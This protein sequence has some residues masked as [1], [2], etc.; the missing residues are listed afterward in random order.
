MI[1]D[2]L[3]ELVTSSQRILLLQG[4]IGPFFKYFADWLVNV[5]GKYVYKLNFNAGDKFYFSSALEQQSIIDYRDT[6]ENFEAFLLQL[7]QENEIDALVC[8]GDTR[9]YHQVAKR[10]SEQLQYSFWA[11][12]EGYF[13]PHYVTL[14][15]EGVNAYSTLPRNKQF[16]LQQAENLTEYIQPIPIAK[17]FF[18]M[19]KL[20]TQYYV[21]ARHREEQFPHYKH[22]RVYNLNYYIKL[23][24]ISGLKRVCR[25]VKEKRFIRKIEQNK[26]GDFYILPLQV[27]DDSQVKVHCDFD[28]VE[29]FLIY[30]LNSFVKN[31]PKSL[32]LVIKHH[33]MDRGFISYKNVIKCYLSEHPELQGRVFYVY[34]VPMPVLLRYGKAMVTLNSTS[35]LSALIHNMPVMTLGLANYNIPDITHQGTLEE[36]WH[37]PQ[38]PDEKAFKAY[39]LYH[40]HKTQ[41]NGSFYNKVILP[42]EKI[43]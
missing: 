12:E 10:V 38:Q 7:C 41:I 23:W 39:H 43:E 40:L 9:P 20:A 13:R 29:A 6:F 21:V 30:V 36:F 14:E 18:P 19:A 1:V 11:F 33:P 31:A 16:F 35:G 15:K 4:P 32:S 27:Y 2:N 8:F 24:L 26:L 42:E 3:T 5:Q 34:D 37:T 22:H 25:Y 28:S 17:G